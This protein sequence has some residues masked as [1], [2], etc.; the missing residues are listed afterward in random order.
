MTWPQLI[1]GVASRTAVK[2]MGWH[3][4]TRISYREVASLI[5]VVS[6]LAG[7]FAVSDQ[8]HLRLPFPLRQW[9]GLDAGTGCL[10]L[11]IL[12]ANGLSY[13]SRARSTT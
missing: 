8:G 1:S 6:G 4:G 12:K 11:V 5:L 2:A 10:W 9:H 7:A 3:S 13:T